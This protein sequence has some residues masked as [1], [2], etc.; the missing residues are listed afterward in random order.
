M[1]PHLHLILPGMRGGAETGWRGHGGAGRGSTAGLE[2][3]LVSPEL[4]EF[5]DSLWEQLEKLR[6]PHQN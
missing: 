3:P 4:L 1:A 2:L 5:Q 6:L